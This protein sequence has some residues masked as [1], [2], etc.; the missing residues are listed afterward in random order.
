MLV[1]PPEAVRGAGLL[2]AVVA[3]YVYVTHPALHNTG[4][5]NPISPAGQSGVLP[6]DVA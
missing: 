4:P 5:I 6:L 3:A 1:R 2:R